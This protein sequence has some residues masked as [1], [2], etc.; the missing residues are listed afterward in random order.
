MSSREQEI[1]DE[2]KSFM[3]HSELGSYESQNA[4]TLW[5]NIMQ[6]IKIF[7]NAL[8]SEE[9]VIP[10]DEKQIINYIKVKCNI[11]DKEWSNM[12]EEQQD[13]II[14]SESEEYIDV[15][16]NICKLD[17]VTKIK[18]RLNDKCDKIFLFRHIPSVI[19]FIQPIIDKG[20]QEEFKITLEFLKKENGDE[21]NEI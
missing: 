4:F 13:D 1:V 20:E 16:Q 6:K 18:R 14:D 5:Q 15:L 8:E 21:E 2:L 11:S 10:A 3:L 19:T 9:K 7:E 12:T 17:Y